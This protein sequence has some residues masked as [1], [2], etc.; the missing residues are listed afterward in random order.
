[1]LTRA[2]LLEEKAQATIESERLAQAKLEAMKYK[3]VDLQQQVSEQEQAFNQSKY[4]IAQEKEAKGEQKK[5]WKIELW[6]SLEVN[7]KLGVYMYNF[8]QLGFDRCTSQFIDI[9]YPLNDNIEFLYMSAALAEVAQDLF[10]FVPQ[11]ARVN[12]EL[13]L[14]GRVAPKTLIEQFLV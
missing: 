13:F 10:S 2:T 14:G 11:I 4:E 3:F 5:R 12:I 9:G 1:M 8:F 6:F 7:E